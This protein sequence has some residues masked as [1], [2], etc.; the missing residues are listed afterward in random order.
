M[1][2][3]EAEAVGRAMT[4]ILVSRQ[5]KKVRQSSIF[6]GEVDAEIED[7]IVRP[8]SSVEHGARVHLWHKA[9]IPYLYGFENLADLANENTERFLDFAGQLVNLLL[10]RVIRSAEARLAPMQQ[11]NALRTHSQAMIAGWNFPESSLVRQL[12]SGIAEECVEKSLEPNASLGGGA[13]AFGIPMTEFIR[14]AQDQP[15][16]AR[17]L[18]FGVAYNVFALT[19]DQR[20]KNKDWCLIELSGPVLLSHGLTLQR[21]GFLE[22]RVA[23]MERI[24][25][26]EEGRA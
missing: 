22:R 17:I 3:V 11:F 6:D 16:L 21:G 10:T 25:K 23:D 2:G 8:T 13:S 9:E 20:A 15:D 14:I 12:A 5:G 18:Q 19:P 4:A 7:H 24:V 26:R 1:R